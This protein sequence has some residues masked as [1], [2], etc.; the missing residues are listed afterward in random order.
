VDA[1]TLGHVGKQLDSIVAEMFSSLSRS[2]QRAKA[3]LYTRGLM[4]DGRPART[5]QRGQ[6]AAQIGLRVRLGGVR[7]CRQARRTQICAP[8]KI[9]APPSFVNT[10]LRC[11]STP[12]PVQ[13]A[14]KAIRG[15]VTVGID[16][17]S[18]SMGMRDWGRP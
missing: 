2:D 13:Q 8:D 12:A 11:H 3:A 7:A 16:R 17:L 18:V 10:F 5:R 6:P 15:R 1:V 4:L 9:A 14:P